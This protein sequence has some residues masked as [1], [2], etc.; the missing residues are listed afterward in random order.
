M[1]H[2]V[3][4]ILAIQVRE[5]AETVVQRKLREG[6]VEGFQFVRITFKPFVSFR[7]WK[8]LLLN[9]DTLVAEEFGI[10]EGIPR[11]FGKM[12]ELAGPPQSNGPCRQLDTQV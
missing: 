3:L 6:N 7:H 2:L 1:N 12:A 4:R 5:R 10:H 8:S 9:D 11:G